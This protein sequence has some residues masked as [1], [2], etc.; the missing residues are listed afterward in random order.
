[1][2]RFE[3]LYKEDQKHIRL[4]EKHYTDKQ[5]HKLNRNIRKQL[6]KILRREKKLSPREHFI[7]AMIYHHGFTV[8]SSK[9]ALYHIKIAQKLGYEKQKWLIASIIDRLLQLNSRPQKY[10]TQIIKTKTGKIKQ[11]KVDGMIKDIERISLGLPKL[12]ELKKYLEK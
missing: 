9:K 7:C 8:T 12:K 5:F 11:Y 1:M 10:G 4:W 3:Q 6:Q 2:P